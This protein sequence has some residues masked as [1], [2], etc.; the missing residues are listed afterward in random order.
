ML[1]SEITERQAV[2]LMPVLHLPPSAQQQSRA[3][4]GNPRQELIDAARSGASSNDLRARGARVVTQATR[5]LTLDRGAPFPLDHWFE[6]DDEQATRLQSHRCDQC[7]IRVRHNDELRCPDFACWDLK[8]E[9]WSDLRLTEAEAASSIPRLVPDGKYGSVETFYSTSDAPLATEIVKDGCPRERLRLKFEHKPRAGALLEG[10]DDIRVV[11][12]H[13]EGDRCHCLAAK[14]SAQTRERN[15]NDPELQAR[16]EREKQVCDLTAPAYEALAQALVAGHP[17][18]WKLLLKRLNHAYSGKGKDWDLDKIALKVAAETM[19]A[20][21]YWNKDRPDGARGVIAVYFEEAGLDLPWPAPDPIAP[22]RRQFERIEG[23]FTTTVRQHPHSLQAIAGNQANLVRLIDNLEPLPPGKQ[24]D[25]LAA[26]I[27]TLQLQ[28]SD[29]AGVVQEWDFARDDAI[30][31]NS[32]G[33]CL[34]TT[35]T[36]DPRFQR[37]VDQVT[38]PA[39]IRYAAA[40]IGKGNGHA[41]RLEALSA[42][43]LLLE[44]PKVETARSQT[45]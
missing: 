23:W 40:L 25:E 14:K 45:Q 6:V 43:M 2:A 31:W 20:N 11:C 19:S 15:Q 29:V 1:Q 34:L 3:Y 4:G 32:Y 13:G 21:L 5:S 28:L 36:D 42:R 17:G 24:G 44:S 10:F 38:R 18:A 35:P 16:R 9:L 39:V 7:I 22:I 27:A 30:E 37:D 33:N 8:E 41:D 26:R 12:H